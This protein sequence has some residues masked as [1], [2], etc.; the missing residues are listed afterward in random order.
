VFR[1]FASHS[2]VA[3]GILC[4]PRLIYNYISTLHTCEHV[5]DR[6]IFSLFK[7]NLRK[8][9]KFNEACGVL[10]FAQRFYHFKLQTKTVLRLALSN[11]KN[12]KAFV[13]TNSD[14]IFCWNVRLSSLM[15][16][17][18]SGYEQEI[19]TNNK[20]FYCTHFS[21]TWF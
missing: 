20:G 12:L 16:N 9:L 13:N 11:K 10:C 17:F 18:L 5:N 15:N 19:G 4:V 14:N 3:K 1:N 21:D 8:F 2:H 6:S 7:N